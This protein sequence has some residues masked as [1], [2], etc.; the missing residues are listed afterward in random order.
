MRLIVSVGFSQGK[1]GRIRPD[2]GNAARAVMAGLWSINI[3]YGVFI[4]V[5]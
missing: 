1:C 2:W 5:L 4:K 3:I